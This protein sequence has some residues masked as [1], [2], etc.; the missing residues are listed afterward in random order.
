[1]LATEE[2]VYQ[3]RAECIETPRF[4]FA[5]SR[6]MWLTPIPTVTD[7]SDALSPY[8]QRPDDRFTLVACKA[9][10][11]EHAPVDFNVDAVRG[12]CVRPPGPST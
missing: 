4:R 5:C 1:M 2:R 7:R 12:T 3:T 8:R 11:T 9:P 10:G 6:L